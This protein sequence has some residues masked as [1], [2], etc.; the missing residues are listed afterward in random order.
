M[1][2]QEDYTTRKD[3][4]ILIRTYSDEG[5]WIR[6]E[7]GVEYEEAI[8][9]RRKTYVETSRKRENWTPVKESEGVQVYTREVETKAGEWTVVAELEKEPA[10]IFFFSNG[11]HV[12]CAWRY[13]G[14]RVECYTNEAYSLTV[15]ILER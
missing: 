10:G 14:Y 5:W 7:D 8:D 15:K 11:Q 13:V 1:I 2:V 9:C 12:T 6:N 4:A 3:G